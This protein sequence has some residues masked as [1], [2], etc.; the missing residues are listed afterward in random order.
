M[1]QRWRIL[2]ALVEDPVSSLSS[3]VIAHNPPYLQVQF[4]TA[5]CPP[6]VLGMLVLPRHACRQRIHIHKIKK[7]HVFIICVYAWVTHT[8]RTSCMH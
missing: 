8:Q 6:V 2:I 4:D 7:L 1:A 5:I 3:P